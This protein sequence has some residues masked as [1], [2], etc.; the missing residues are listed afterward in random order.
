MVL[1]VVGS[2]QVTRMRVDSR[3]VVHASLAFVSLT[4]LT[5]TLGALGPR[6]FVTH[7]S[8]RG[9]RTTSS[10]TGRILVYRGK[11]QSME[12]EHQMMWLEVDVKRPAGWGGRSLQLVFE[13]SA[14]G[15]HEQLADERFYAQRVVCPK[16]K[17]WCRPVGVF[18]QHA[19]L[20]NEYEVEAYAIE[21]QQTGYP[22][23]QALTTRAR[24]KFVNREFTAFALW[25][26][27]CLEAVSIAAL[28]M[29]VA[30]LWRVERPTCDQ[31][32][33]GL[34]A[35]ALVVFFECPLFAVE[36][37]AGSKKASLVVAIAYIYVANAFVG[38]LLAHFASRRRAPKA[39]TS[40]LCG[41]LAVAA[42]TLNVFYRLED[43]REP[44]YS[45]SGHNHVVH[46]T[47]VLVVVLVALYLATFV[48]SFRRADC[49]TAQDRL[50]ALLALAVQA[51]V[52]TAIF[53][54]GFDTVS[55]SALRFAIFRG[56]PNFYVWV[57]VYLFAPLR[58]ANDAPPP[59]PQRPKNSVSSST[60][61]EPAPEVDADVELHAMV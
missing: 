17:T 25:F 18:S 9:S 14:S 28:V 2:S 6:V 19:I 38:L 35:A 21:P 12:P 39:H 8:S 48:L 11:I 27:I 37:Y 13:V 22:S 5:L 26:Y 54:G 45:S 31:R 47:A 61:N 42:A 23:D 58:T 20:Y 46:A 50:L 55:Q 34:L 36:I 60:S 40:A 49:Q 15:G 44:A 52:L 57:L 16:R 51:T 53:L 24:L 4:A 10:P 30:R 3:H 59:L 43:S 41:A 33:T 32:W 29:F 56:V 1:L 7:S